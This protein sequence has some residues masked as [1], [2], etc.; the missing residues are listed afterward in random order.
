MS[1]QNHHLAAK[2]VSNGIEIH[3]NEYG[4]G[5]LLVLLHGFPDVEET[6]LHQANELKKHYRVVTPRL[7]G[8]PPSSVPN[9]VS[10]YALPELA[11]D[12]KN[13]IEEFGGP[14]IIV[15]HD[16]GGAIAQLTALLYPDLVCGLVLC[17]SSLISRF[18]ALVNSDEEQQTLSSYTLPYFRYQE[19]DEKR[20]PEIVEPIRDE[21]WRAYI[22]DYLSSNPIEGMLSYYKANF[23]QPPYM[24]TEPSGYVFNTP[25]LIIW[26]REEHAFSSKALDG[27]IQFFPAGLTIA[28]IPNAGHWVHRDAPEIFNKTLKSWLSTLSESHTN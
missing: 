10:S 2:I 25:T 23:P 16:W 8:F 14:A 20:I 22:A 9:A 15:G 12:I 4:Q 7:R 27:A 28:S 26:G 5:P 18:D 13:L 11:G 17:N 21:A 19:G 24:P 6:F 1:V 3:F